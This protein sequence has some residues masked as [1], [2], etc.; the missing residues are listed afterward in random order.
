[1]HEYTIAQKIIDDA[2]RNGEVKSIT[3]E[4]GDLAH[5]STRET[6]EILEKLTDWKVVVI[7]KQAL[8]TCKCGY[9]GE[10]KILIHSHDNTI[11]ECPK[12][13]FSLPEPIKGRHIKLKEVEI[14]D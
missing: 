1:M 6:K 10:P 8:V 5:L 11:Y 7:R 9:F 3:V 12:C 13:G 14:E 2:K 4:V